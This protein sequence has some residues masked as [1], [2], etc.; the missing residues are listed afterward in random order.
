MPILLMMFLFT[1][2]AINM[3]VAGTKSLS[4][5]V[6]GHVNGSYNI[7]AG[8]SVNVRLSTLNNSTTNPLEYDR[9]G[10]INWANVEFGFMD[11]FDLVYLSGGESVGQFG[12]KMKIFGPSRR[13][14]K[15]GDS[16]LS[17]YI[18]GGKE[19]EDDQDDSF[20]FSTSKADIESKV[21]SAGLLYG[22]RVTSH[23]IIGM[24]FFYDSY[25][26]S[27]EFTA[28]SVPALV[29]EKFDYDGKVLN[30]ALYTIL[31][32]QSGWYT[33]LEAALQQNDWQ[34]TDKYTV[35][36]GSIAFGATF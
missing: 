27:G 25:N 22:H 6:Q 32:S 4:P 28:N 15:Q 34:R 3:D 9:S 18:G 11:L 10:S 36:L 19:S 30:F 12:V 33:R 5:E 35:G 7:S 29:G 14:A 20:V 17:F 23:T 16:S 8:Q 24:S 31:Y 26:F 1:S 13:V 21:V 2:C